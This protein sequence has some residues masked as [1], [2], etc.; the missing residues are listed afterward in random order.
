MSNK[1][2]GIREKRGGGV[3][4]RGANTKEGNNFSYSVEN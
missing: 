3:G 2:E 1:I 4:R